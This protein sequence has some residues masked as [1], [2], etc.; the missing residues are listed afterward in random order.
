[1][2]AGSPSRPPQLTGALPLLGNALDFFKDPVA[3]VARG[4]REHG[5]VFGLSLAGKPVVVM[6]GPE[7]HR[8]FFDE[9]DAKLSL[10]EPYAFMR[11]IFGE[12]MYLMASAEEYRRQ[13]TIV[14]PW[15]QGRR[16]HGYVGSMVT[17]TLGFLERLGTEGEFE[18]Y[19]ALGPLVMQV[20]ARTFLGDE[21]RQKVGADFFDIFRDFA[22]GIE[23]YLPLWLP[24]PRFKRSERARARLVDM[25]AASIAERRG[26]KQ[27]RDDF[28][29]LLIES[30]Y[31]DGSPV[32]DSILINWIIG[33]TWAG[34]E[35]TA[36][37][38]G[39]GLA[40]LLQHPDY[41]RS[42]LA[43]Q[44]PILA[45][46]EDPAK[47]DMEQFKRLK[48]IEWSLK[49][50]ERLHPVAMLI[51]RLATQ[52]LDVAGYRIDKGTLVFL[53]PAVAHRL[54]E[55]FARPH[56]YDPERFS[57]ERAEDKQS[58]SLVGFGGG[59]H[60]CVGAHFAALEMKII[61]TLL[62]DRYDLELIDE[63]RPIGGRAP[64]G[65]PASPCR[66]RYR[67]RMLQATDGQ[68]RNEP[69]KVNSSRAA[70]P[71]SENAAGCPVH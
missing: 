37:H 33:F 69:A 10:K 26:Q 71:A 49:E 54:P 68:G 62:L 48:R 40:D 20:A 44:S 53:C 46:V 35:T 32:P 28:F 24:L 11:K 8:L 15:F 27:P 31:D 63:P 14:L 30:R 12:D 61:L 4:L 60:R 7:H 29:Q 23:M 57:P 2:P 42:V 58:H 45:E 65:R 67:R 56:A 3:L 5:R 36:G 9:T 22:G 1:V 21:F 51:P 66:V 25:I 38:I 43:E 59:T 34:H 19:S 50:T 17:E 47:L 16:V 70:A 55:L 6:L 64:A 52:E 41:L 39:W 18:L 13:R